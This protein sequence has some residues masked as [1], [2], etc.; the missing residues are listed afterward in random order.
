MKS[1]RSREAW[2]GQLWHGRLTGTTLVFA[3]VVTVVSPAH[4]RVDP[5]DLSPGHPTGHVDDR[6]DQTWPPQPRGL[7]NVV[8]LGTPGAAERAAGLRQRRVAALES[9]A[10]KGSEV[11]QALGHRYSSPD[12]VEAA[13]KGGPVAGES[14]LVYFSYENNTTVEVTVAGQR[15]RGVR[16]IPATE[17]QPDITDGEAVEASDLARQYFV[18]RGRA[19]V[20]D[21]QAF[22]ILAYLP[23][24]KGFYPMRVIYVSFHQDGD[25][26]PECAAWVDLTNQ[27][28]LRIREEQP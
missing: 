19:G 22:G 11:R 18:S 5:A 10:L 17:Y 16:K 20:A 3:L 6:A 14:R 26:P 7:R 21:L 28:V 1:G 8:P 12:F 2:P 25:A 24:G 4:N 9:M 23:T 13:G 27:R 15:V